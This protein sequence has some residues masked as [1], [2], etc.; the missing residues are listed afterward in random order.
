M[1]LRRANT[2]PTF[3]VIALSSNTRHQDAIEEDDA[4]QSRDG[5]W[6]QCGEQLRDGD[7][8]E[9]GRSTRFGD[10]LPSRSRPLATRPTHDAG[11]QGA[12]ALH[13]AWLHPRPAGLDRPAAPAL[14]RATPGQLAGTRGGRCPESPARPTPWSYAPRYLDDPGLMSA[15]IRTRLPMI[16]PASPAGPH[17]TR[18][19]SRAPPLPSR[20]IGVYGRVRFR[21][22]VPRCASSWPAAAVAVLVLAGSGCR[23]VYLPLGVCHR[24]AGPLLSRRVS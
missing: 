6:A 22:S 11:G 15:Q 12:T 4:A 18:P 24:Q 7:P 19:S 17:Q 10:D 5:A 21:I 1:P 3:P 23:P 13:P 14:R 20:R 9:R 16:A 2:P 8:V